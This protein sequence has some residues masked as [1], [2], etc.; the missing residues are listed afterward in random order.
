MGYRFL[1]AH[2]RLKGRLV[3]T[4][5]SPGSH[6][7]P[8]ELLP[9]CAAAHPRNSDKD[10]GRRQGGFLGTCHPLKKKKH[11]V[12]H[13]CI[14]QKPCWI[15][16]TPGPRTHPRLLHVTTQDPLF[17]GEASRNSSPKFPDPSPWPPNPGWQGRQELPPPRSASPQRSLQQGYP[18]AC[19]ARRGSARLG[20]PGHT[21][22]GLRVHTWVL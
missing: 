9:A 6:P 13:L 14:P 20:Q 22:C 16:G 11:H 7:L 18:P 1:S 5:L 15:N 19:E 8:S 10:G 4:T 12:G 21:R 3:P 17:V 2:F